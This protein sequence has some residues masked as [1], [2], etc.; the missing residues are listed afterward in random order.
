[1]KSKNLLIVICLVAVMV[2]IPLIESAQAAPKVIV[3]RRQTGAPSLLWY[4]Q[5]NIVLGGANNTIKI[6]DNWNGKLVVLCR[7]YSSIA[8]FNPNTI[9]LDTLSPLF[10]VKGYATAASNYGE[11]GY[12]VKE[13]VIRT[14]QLTEYVLDNYG[15]T[16]NV[17]LA[18]ISMGGNIVL[19]LGAKYPELYDGVL[20]ICGSKDLA[21]QY[22]DKMYYASIADDIALGKEVV[23]RGGVNPPYPLPTIAAF[24]DYCL[25]SGTEIALACGGTPAEK[26]KAYE[27]ISP[28]FNAAD[29]ALPTIT[30][31]GTADALVPYST[32]IEFMNA[33]VAEGQSSLYRIYKVVGGQHANTPV[34]GQISPRFDQLVN[35][36]ENG[37]L[38]PASTP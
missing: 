32:S 34:L 28:T 25:T 21:A 12:C 8:G 22:T 2:A 36:V 14:H 15:V 33:V 7:G 11:G 37:V 4:T 30:V 27:R 16:G 1:M 18:G 17:Y 29:I 35:W 13:G 19:Q 9:P 20:D 38:P 23:D 24:R 3:T 26:P 6:P 10:I 5:T 31:H